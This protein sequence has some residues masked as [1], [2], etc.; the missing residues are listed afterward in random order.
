[1][2]LVW[3]GG[4]ERLYGKPTTEEVLGRILTR[5]C[6]LHIETRAIAIK[7]HLTPASVGLRKQLS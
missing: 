4:Q 7:L 2:P 3:R 5:T 6:V 1:M